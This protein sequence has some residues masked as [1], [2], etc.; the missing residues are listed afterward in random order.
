MRWSPRRA[1]HRCAQLSFASLEAHRL[2]C[3]TAGAAQCIIDMPP[4]MYSVEAPPPRP[5]VLSQAMNTI[6]LHPQHAGPVPRSTAFTSM[7]RDPLY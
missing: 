2:L 1:T 4:G 7:F 6:G 3:A 5:V